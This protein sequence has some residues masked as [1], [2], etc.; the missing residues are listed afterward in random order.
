MG[1][2]EGGGERELLGGGID[3]LREAQVQ[4]RG[5]RSGVETGGSS[6]GGPLVREQRLTISLRRDP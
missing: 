3:R 2:S 6:H 1:G 4:G 5:S